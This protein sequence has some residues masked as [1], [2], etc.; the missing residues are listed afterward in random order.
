VAASILR[1]ILFK[2]G[3][4]KKQE[5]ISPRIRA[6]QV[7]VGRASRNAILIY[8][9][10][11][12]LPNPNLGDIDEKCAACFRYNDVYFDLGDALANYNLLYGYQSI[13]REGRLLGMD[14]DLGEDGNIQFKAPDPLEDPSEGS[15]HLD[16]DEE[17]DEEQD[18]DEEEDEVEESEHES[19][20]E[21]VVRDESDREFVVRDDVYIES[22]K[23]RPPPKI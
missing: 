18:D 21:F 8:P 16:K 19:D 11:R 17:K 13:Q 3:Q 22:P 6:F 10:E 20:R 9:Q 5:Q 15:Q 12:G 2:R 23:P 1:K 4:E 7:S 14:V